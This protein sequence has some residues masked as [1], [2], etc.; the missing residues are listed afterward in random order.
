MTE[1]FFRVRMDLA[2]RMDELCYLYHGEK[3]VIAVGMDSSKGIAILFKDEPV[4][5]AEL[6]VMPTGGTP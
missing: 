6:E 4:Q 3:P 1:D 5:I 2:S